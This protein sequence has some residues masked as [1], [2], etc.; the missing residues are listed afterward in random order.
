MPGADLQEGGATNQTCLLAACSHVDSSYDRK[1]QE[2][3]HNAA[4][5]AGVFYE[6]ARCIGPF[7]FPAQPCIGGISL[8]M[9]PCTV[10]TH[11][12]LV[13]TLQRLYKDSSGF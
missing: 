13:T 9:R 12:L 1:K 11:T 6:L 5:A 2:R 4:G 8:V 10:C 3:T 7:C